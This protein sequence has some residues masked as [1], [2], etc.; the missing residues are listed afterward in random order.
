MN[1]ELSCEETED[2]CEMEYDMDVFIIEMD[3]WE[4]VKFRPVTCAFRD[5]KV[6]R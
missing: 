1:Y 5:W 2:E 3:N 4:S 6:N